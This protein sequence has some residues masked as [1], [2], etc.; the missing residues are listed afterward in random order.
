MK[1]IAI[2]TITE[3]PTSVAGRSTACLTSI[4]SVAQILYHMQSSEDNSKY[5][6][7]SADLDWFELLDFLIS[8]LEEQPAEVLPSQPYG[9]WILR[10]LN[11]KYA[12]K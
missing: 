3:I 4:K 1:A 6:L 9:V 7:P 11:E 12:C 8:Y 10:A 5:C 2:G